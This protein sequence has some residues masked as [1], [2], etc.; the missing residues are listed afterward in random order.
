M[1]VSV[2]IQRPKVKVTG[3]KHVKIVF[4][5][6]IH[7]TSIGLRPIKTKMI[8]VLPFYTYRQIHFTSVFVIFICNYPGW[9]HVAAAIWPCTCLF[10]SLCVFSTGVIWCTMLPVLCFVTCTR[11]CRLVFV[12]S[13]GQCLSK[14]RR[15]S[16]LYLLCW[17]SRETLRWLL[18]QDSPPRLDQTA[19]RL[20]LNLRQW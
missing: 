3:I 1:V 10:E 14:C 20:V 8:I 17:D 16:S 2:G 7:R 4:R 5:A 19:L 12:C 15:S 9:P 11:S 13:T 18:H 6:Y